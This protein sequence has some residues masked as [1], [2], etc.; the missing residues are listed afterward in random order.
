MRKTTSEIQVQRTKL[1]IFTNV[2]IA[3]DF[4]V[5]LAEI[6]ELVD[7]AYYDHV[8]TARAICQALR[9]AEEAYKSQQAGEVER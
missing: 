3:S 4:N 6:H 9:A 8:P 1:K 2:L 5:D 7:A